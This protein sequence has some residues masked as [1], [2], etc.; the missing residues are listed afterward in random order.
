MVHR[1]NAVSRE[2]GWDRLAGGHPAKW[3][4]LM[5]GAERLSP[6]E[7]WAAG[8][9]V[10]PGGGPQAPLKKPPSFWAKPNREKS[11]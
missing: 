10:G 11:T 2:G 8:L 1:P 6:G 4:G 3:P 9:T 5:L 7:A